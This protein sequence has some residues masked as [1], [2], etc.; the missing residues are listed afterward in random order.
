MP[1]DNGEAN[2]KPVIEPAQY[3]TEKDRILAEYTR[4]IAALKKELE[5][6]RA[7]KTKQESDLAQAK[8]D[9]EKDRTAIAQRTQGEIDALRETAANLDSLIKQLNSSVALKRAEVEALDAAISV[10]TAEYQKEQADLSDAQAALQAD[11]ALLATEKEAHKTATAELSTAKTAWAQHEKN[12]REMLDAVIKDA[13][14]EVA[15]AE[16][17]IKAASDARE[18]ANKAKAEAEAAAASAQLVIEEARAAQLVLDSLKAE[19]EALDVD[20]A[21]L[22]KTAEH[23][24]IQT[25]QNKIENERL[26]QLKQ[27]LDKRERAIKD[28][29]AA[30]AAKL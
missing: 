20:R 28:G 15:K 18:S 26:L 6:L 10:K 2:V 3:K 9:F 30:L 1:Y 25:N 21:N 24:N 13:H 27:S 22:K 29:E 8:I 5:A 14:V 4:N 23:L 12:Q 17:A 11:R 16:A 7:D 19:K